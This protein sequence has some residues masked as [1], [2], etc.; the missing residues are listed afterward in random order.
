MLSWWLIL[1]ILFISGLIAYLGD[2]VGRKVGKQRLT[3]FGLRPRYTSVIITII[4]GILI[5]GFSVTFIFTAFSNVRMAIFNI[6]DVLSQLATLSV[7]V[8]SRDTQLKE[9]RQEIEETEQALENIRQERSQLQEELDSLTLENEEAQMELEA[10]KQEIVE[11][12]EE[13]DILE[14]ILEESQERLTTLER[15]RNELEVKVDD[16]EQDIVALQGAY[17]LMEHE[18]DIRYRELG[19][20]YHALGE[21]YQEYTEGNIIYLRG[22]EI[23]RIVV[24]GELGESEIF[25]LMDTFLREANE[26]AQN[27]GVE[28][29]DP[30][31]GRSIIFYMGEYLAVAREIFNRE[32]RFVISLVAENNTVPGQELKARF[33]VTEDYV[34]YQQGET[35]LTRVFSPNLNPYELEEQ[36]NTLFYDLRGQVLKDGLLTDA[37]G[38]VG[39]IDFVAFYNILDELRDYEEPMKVAVLASKNIWRTDTL[40]DNIEFTFFPAGD[41]FDPGY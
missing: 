19:M 35:I 41:N 33:N 37:H 26:L 7:Q 38:H 22:Q 25:H 20:L 18:Y 6:Q 29:H 34:V 31:T 24:E 28:P 17:D 13:R 5:A 40:T 8:Q 12:E 32:G 14:S 36:L 1:G 3:L 23:H 30:E 4:T 11:L 9:L 2:V 21:R 27:R 10:A 39:S 15:Q 16:L